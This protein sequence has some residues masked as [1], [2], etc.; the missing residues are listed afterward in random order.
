MATAADIDALLTLELEGR[1]LSPQKFLGGI[2]AF[3]GIVEEVTRS[4]CEDK[5][6][7]MW[8]VQ[9]KAGSNLVGV[10]PVPGFPA[11][12]VALIADSVAKGI[13]DLE[14]GPAEPRHFSHRAIRHLHDLAAI[15]GT[16][17]RD[18]IEIKVWVRKNA[19]DLTH[20][21][22]VH[23]AELLTAAYADHGSIEGRLQVLSERR[24]L[25]VVVYEPLWDK[26][27]RCHLT[28]EQTEIAL[29]NFGKRVEVVG[30]VRYRGDGVPVSIDVE[31]I[32]PF[33]APED[34]PTYLAVRGILRDAP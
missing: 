6:R 26:P 29:K 24:G 21:S 10:E 5:P 4:V 7:V 33:P 11:P 19:S 14:Q 2:K 1:T 15:V 12:I 31:E 18:D 3:F 25:H 20:R 30:L 23:T 32:V 16:D 17:E 34:I 9:V 27:V 22:V 28:D 13:T 8:R